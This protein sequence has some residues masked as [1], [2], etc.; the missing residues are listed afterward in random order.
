MFSASEITRE[1]AHERKNSK[2]KWKLRK[3]EIN[4]KTNQ[5][6]KLKRMEIEEKLKP[7][8]EIKK[9]V[10]ENLGKTRTRNGY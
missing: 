10:I 3:M 8:R 2:Q 7:E 1:V 5:K 6:W 4:E 9:N